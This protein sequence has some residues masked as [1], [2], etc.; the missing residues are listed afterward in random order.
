MSN[1]GKNKD[2]VDMKKRKNSTGSPAVLCSTIQ[3]K[4]TN[5]WNTALRAF[6]ELVL[7]PYEDFYHRKVTVREYIDS[8]DMEPVVETHWGV[9]YRLGDLMIYVLTD[10]IPE[11]I[12]D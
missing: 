7:R 2:T 3:Y 9:R 5:L 1:V 11:A 10:K 4:D 12:S 8:L 6:G